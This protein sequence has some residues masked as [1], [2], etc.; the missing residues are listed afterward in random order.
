VQEADRD[1][2]RAREEEG[3]VILVDIDADMQA[4]DVPQDDHRLSHPGT[5]DGR[6]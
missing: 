5:G 3:E 6:Q 4:V 1:R 2:L